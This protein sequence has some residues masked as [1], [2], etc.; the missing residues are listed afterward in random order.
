MR[1]A[2]VVWLSLLLLVTWI[3]APAQAEFRTWKAAVGNFSIEAEFVELKANNIVRLQLKD[4]GTRE[5]ALDKLSAKD[6]E[7]VAA[8]I[9]PSASPTPSSSSPDKKPTASLGKPDP[10]RI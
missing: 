6:Q 4:G 1:Q 8:K 9:T 2:R 3:A 10:E 7:Y 5:V